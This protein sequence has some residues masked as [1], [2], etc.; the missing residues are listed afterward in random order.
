MDTGTPRRFDRLGDETTAVALDARSEFDH[1]R[2][3]SPREPIQEGGCSRSA[4]SA[5][6]HDPP[7]RHIGGEIR[8]RWRR[9]VVCNGMPL[10]TGWTMKSRWVGVLTV[11]ASVLLGAAAARAAEG[12]AAPG[13]KRELSGK[14]IRTEANTLY[15]E[16]M[17]AVVPVV[18][19]RDTRFSGI[20]SAG[21]LAEGQEVRASFTVR[22]DTKNVA[23]S[24][25]LGAPPSPPP[26]P[27]W[28][29]G[30]QDGGG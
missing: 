29:D 15:L 25:S 6:S 4:A 11:G 22:D 18:I 21:Q 9:H 24:I 10:E 23:H 30:S 14:V 28:E 19:G 13:E 20:P 16:H 27:S 26:A 1:D 5:L 17:G 8:V 12:A 7:D 2:A 3:V